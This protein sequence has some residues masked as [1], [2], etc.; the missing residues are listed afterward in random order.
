[1]LMSCHGLPHAH[2]VIS[3]LKFP[4]AFTIDPNGHTIWYAERYNGEIHRR[5][6]GAVLQAVPADHNAFLG[7]KASARSVGQAPGPDRER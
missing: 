3:S 5:E 4:A 1:M 7:E 6:L 2:A